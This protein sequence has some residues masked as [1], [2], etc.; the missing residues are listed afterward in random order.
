[1]IHTIHN[2]SFIH[3][4]DLGSSLSALYSTTLHPC[5]DPL[6]VSP[7]GRLVI[8]TLSPTLYDGLSYAALEWGLLMCALA[9]LCFLHS[10]SKYMGYFR[11][12]SKKDA[13]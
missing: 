8:L 3:A 12:E 2:S 4:N 1:M 7:T 5:S 9:W 11:V 10:Q 6:V 13:D